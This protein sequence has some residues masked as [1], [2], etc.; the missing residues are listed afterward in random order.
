MDHNSDSNNTGWVDECMSKL[1]PGEEFQ[2][3]VTRA[4]ARFARRRAFPP[5]RRWAL[6]AAA[7]AVLVS[8]MLAFPAPRVLASRCVDACESFFGGKPAVSFDMLKAQPA[9][10]F[11]VNDST[12]APIRLSDYRGKVVL[13]NFWATWC[14]PCKT[15][16]PWFIEFEQAYQDQRFAVIGI[17][18]DDDG[19][20][21]VRPYIDARKWNYRVGVD[22]GTIAPKYGGVDS[23]P[24][25][26]MIDREGRIV[27]RHVGLVSKQTYE[28]E[29][30]ALLKR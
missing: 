20:K 28:S 23:L 29:I 12:G 11:A 26:I 1:G 3:D 21:S 24:E 22:D 16:I 10:D 30:A 14:G 25:T 19:W 5:A 8:G 7:V 9:P 18:L 27:S 15:E 4:L 13:L 6:G 2:P 17:S